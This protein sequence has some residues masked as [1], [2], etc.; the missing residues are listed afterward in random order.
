M[1]ISVDRC[2]CTD[3]TF[4][5]LLSNV[6]GAKLSYEALTRETGAC[7]QCGLC[8]PYVRKCLRTGQVVFHEL[9][10]PENGYSKV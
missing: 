2:I 5:S 3:T 1:S 10:P 9:I 4:A 8:G 6:K 7:L